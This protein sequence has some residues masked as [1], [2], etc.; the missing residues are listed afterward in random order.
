MLGFQLHA[1][2]HPAVALMFKGKQDRLRQAKAEADREIAAYRAE[3]EGAY[4]KKVAEVR[5]ELRCL[6]LRS[7]E[8]QVLYSLLER[9]NG[10]ELVEMRN[11]LRMM[12][13]QREMCL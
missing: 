6:P 8:G 4:Q 10:S 9:R 13:H 3:R 1:P 5:L 2:L 12:Q 11:L 7:L